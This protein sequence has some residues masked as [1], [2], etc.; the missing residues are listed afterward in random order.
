[1]RR[2]F[3]AA[4]VLVLLGVSG[5]VVW[6]CGG[7]GP[8]NNV[9]SPD[10]KIRFAA[11]EEL[12]A[13]G[14][15]GLASLIFAK[16]LRTRVLAQPGLTEEQQKRLTNE[17]ALFDI[18]IDEVG[19]AK[20]CTASQ[21]YWY[22]DLEEAKVAAKYANKP[23]LSLRML[24]KL[25]EEF[26]CANSRFFRTAL[27]ANAEIS[28][29][30]REKYVLHWQSVRPVPKVTI[31][32]GDGRKLER[33]L[34]GNSIHYV[35]AH[36]GRP[37]DGLPGLHG[38]QAFKEWLGRM[39]TLHTQFTQA[40]LARRDELL[41]QFHQA[42]LE[43]IE[44]AWQADLVKSAGQAARENTQQVAQAAPPAA[45]AARV[46]VPKRR[47]EAPLIRS[48]DLTKRVALPE[49]LDALSDEQWQRIAALH[50]EDAALDQS[51]IELMRSQK[52]GAP[53]AGR[54]S[55]SKA[56]VE[57][58]LLRLVRVFESSIALDTVRNEYVLHRQLH[59][60]FITEADVRDVDSLNE[61]VYAQLFL[62]PSSDPW[63]GLVP[64]DTYTALT[65]DGIHTVKVEQK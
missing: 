64:R 13:E 5:G 50:A 40:E 12:R 10:P 23:I 54:L 36:D 38:P 55:I 56:I 29:T 31:D 16:A 35:L 37:L 21:L 20:Y 46:A 49:S 25:N 52:P 27:Y 28:Q 19:G 11:I 47:M 62:T 17:V 3:L 59:R 2:F 42:R 18:A 58:P 1:M 7:Y 9:I 43:A 15:S 53:A 41:T 33:T 34:T 22:T 32:F 65:N 44:A 30:L 61:R 8:G 45:V 57:D 4:L 24:G 51:S 48:V 63:L 60:W 26:S 14:P 39:E 6:S